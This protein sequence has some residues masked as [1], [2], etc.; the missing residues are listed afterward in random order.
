MFS[1]QTSNVRQC[2]QP[3]VYSLNLL[4][5]ITI[6]YITITNSLTILTKDESSGTV[7]YQIGDQLEPNCS[8]NKF[9]NL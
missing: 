1:K 2:S 3:L 5:I 6:I 8:K 9:A 4:F 7:C